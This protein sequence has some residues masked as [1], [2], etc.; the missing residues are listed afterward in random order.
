MSRLEQ[1]AMQLPRNTPYI[2]ELPY[3]LPIIKNGQIDYEHSRKDSWGKVLECCARRKGVQ[4]AREFKAGNELTSPRC[5]SHADLE[6]FATKILSNQVTNDM[7]RNVW[8]DICQGNETSK[9]LK[10]CHKF[11]IT[12]EEFIVPKEHIQKDVISG[13]IWYSYRGDSKQ[14]RINVNAMSIPRWFGS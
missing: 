10:H 6:A 8:C 14:K 3:R 7:H 5:H 9:I 1:Q 13:V 12:R 11:S 4:R 2:W